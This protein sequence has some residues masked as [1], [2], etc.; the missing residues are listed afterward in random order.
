MKIPSE[1]IPQA[2]ELL[3]VVKLVKGVHQGIRTFQNLAQ[4]IEKVQRQGR[5]Y[6]RAAEI[7]GLIENEQNSSHLT[8]LGRKFVTVSPQERDQILANTVLSTRIIQRAIPFLEGAGARGVSKAE[9]ERFIGTVT[10]ATIGPS[11][12]PRRVSTILSWLTQINVVRERDGRYYLNPLPR[13]VELLDYAD[14]DEPLFPK[15]YELD[16]YT[17]LKR[18]IEEKR[19]SL[20]ILIDEAKRDRATNSHKMLTNLMADRIRKAGAIPKRNTVIDLA[21]NI[22]G[23]VFLFEMKS[24]TDDNAHGQ[25]RTGISQLYEY[26]YIQGVKEAKLVL[27]I[28]N[29]LPRKFDWMANYIIQDRGIYLVWDG[30]RKS[31]D[32]PPQVKKDLEFIF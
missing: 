10:E 12:I 22:S 13:G 18:T 7:L 6:R 28:E 2:D 4:Y 32:C 5:Y 15:R 17:A 1:D 16:E 11:M 29:P 31:F 3:D 8:E 20:S 30:N 23:T 14:V 19:G 25:I 26:R 24:T 21:T 9:L 27:V